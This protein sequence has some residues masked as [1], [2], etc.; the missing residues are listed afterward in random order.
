VSA[1][2]PVSAAALG[3]IDDHGRFP[4]ADVDFLRSRVASVA[5]EG[6]PIDHP[7]DLFGDWSA[8]PDRARRVI[9]AILAA[10]MR[11]SMDWYP[12]GVVWTGAAHRLARVAQRT[13]DQG[14][15]RAAATLRRW[16]TRLW[17]APLRQRQ[18]AILAWRARRWLR[19]ARPTLVDLLAHLGRHSHWLEGDWAD[20]VAVDPRC[21]GY[22]HDRTRNVVVGY[23]VGF[24]MIVSERGVWCVEANLNTSFAAIRR[25]VL[26]PEPTIP[27]LMAEAVAMGARRIWW[28]EQNQAPA[29]EWLMDELA[30][31]TRAEGLEFEVFEDWR[32]ARGVRQVPG[33]PPTRRFGNMALD[34]PDHTLVLRRNALPLG[35]DRII[36]NK[37]PFIRGIAAMLEATGDTRVKVPV[38]T[39]RPDLS[40]ATAE[41]GLPNVVYKYPDVGRGEG[42][43]FF[44]ATSEGHAVALARDLD[45]RTGEP[46]GLF[47]PFVCSRLLPGRRIY[48]VRCEFFISPLGVRP[49]FALRREATKPLPEHLEPGIVVTPGVFTSN[50]STGGRF[51]PVDPSEEDEV[52]AGAQGVAEALG[53]LLARAYVTTG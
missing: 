6:T 46:P 29:R 53:R 23:L 18:R 20:A 5:A 42:V 14:R 12:R 7:R 52:W 37:E 35:P 41:E 48:D 10:E 22:H 50:V 34:P 33:L 11:G 4:A 13:T 19:A 24:D 45:R 27:V 3:R 26:N 1:S 43:Y 44:R 36:T 8:L 31:A 16:T 38:M 21:R 39:R 2:P 25:D 15:P 17:A 32:L 30:R 28:V 9:R 47:Q 40:A 49:V 51:A